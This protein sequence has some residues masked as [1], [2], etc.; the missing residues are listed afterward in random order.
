MLLDFNRNTPL[1]ANYHFKAVSQPDR[2]SED[3]H[4]SQQKSDIDWDG[5]VPQLS[6][7]EPKLQVP[8]LLWILNCISVFP[9]NLNFLLK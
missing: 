4:I 9:G 3:V 7:R 1:E 6:H 8:K 2:C 5:D